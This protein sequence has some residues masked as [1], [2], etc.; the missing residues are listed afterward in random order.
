MTINTIVLLDCIYTTPI[1]HLQLLW[2]A[3][4]VTTATPRQT[5]GSLAANL[6]HIEMY[7]QEYNNRLEQGRI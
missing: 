3:T 2:W 6:S 7:S 1:I 4:C 5:D